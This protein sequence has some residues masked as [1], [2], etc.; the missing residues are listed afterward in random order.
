M[1]PNF[2]GRRRGEQAHESLLLSLFHDFL[3]SNDLN[4]SPLL[5]DLKLRLKLRLKPA[6]G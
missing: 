6:A 2:L 5:T 1:C 3:L 4:V